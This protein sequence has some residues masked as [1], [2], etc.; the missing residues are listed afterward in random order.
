MKFLI[1]Q[2]AVCLLSCL[3]LSCQC[4]FCCFERIPNV[5]W[6]AAALEH[7][8]PCLFIYTCMLAM[9]AWV[10]FF[11]NTITQHSLIAC[12]LPNW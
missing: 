1:E 12:K 3:V 4:T 11:D 6:R 5:Y 2:D 8:N 9:R 10:D 7:W